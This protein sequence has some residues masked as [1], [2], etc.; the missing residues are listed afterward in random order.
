[1]RV[2]ISVGGKWYALELAEQLEKR[3][4]LHQ[5][6]T[7]HPPW[8][9]RSQ[10]IDPKKLLS[11]PLAEAAAQGINRLTRSNSGDY[12]KAVLFDRFAS[13][14]LNSCDVLIGF[15]SFCL[16]T[17]RRKKKGCSLVLERAC[18]HIVDQSRC[19]EEE[20]KRLGVRTSVDQR[21]VERMLAEYELADQITVPSAYSQK[22]FLAHGFNPKKVK[23]IPLSGKFPPPLQL[24][25]RRPQT[26]FRLLYVGGSFLR[27]GMIYLLRAWETLRLQ[28]AELVLR[29]SDCALTPEVQRILKNPTIKVVGYQTDLGVLY[30]E[31]SAFCLPSIDEGFGM[32]VL[33]A[34]SYGL[35]VIV[36]EN[37]GAADCLREGIDGFV[38]RIRDPE[39][40]REKILYLYEHKEQR[41]TMGQAARE[42]S[43]RFTWDVYG[44][45]VA[46][47][48]REL[49]GADG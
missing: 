38:V 25:D 27:K 44:D 35:P 28:N 4:Y 10:R 6:V 9:F 31:A 16:T 22:S 48:A 7:S 42:Q 32:V 14:H 33:E 11:F 12:W 26:A 21:M 45:R 43:L 8:A 40:I 3:G 20:A 18:P 19:I 39:A 49:S 36:T 41:L 37:V 23:I 47:T 34:M 13:T 30:S 5:I 2:T 1:M 24:P 29:T 46:Q 17:M 15:A